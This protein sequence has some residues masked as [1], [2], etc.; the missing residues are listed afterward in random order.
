MQMSGCE[1]K[2]RSRLIN[3]FDVYE[4]IQMTLAENQFMNKILHERTYGNYL[5]VAWAFIYLYQTHTYL[6]CLENQTVHISKNMAL[7]ASICYSCISRKPLT[8]DILCGYLYILTHNSSS[9][10]LCFTFLWSSSHG[11]CILL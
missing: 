7:Y 2:W 10:R 6:N 11:F 3:Y 4:H 5:E 8:V 1:N 9:V